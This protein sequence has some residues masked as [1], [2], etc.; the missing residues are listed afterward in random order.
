[1]GVVYGSSCCYGGYPGRTRVVRL[2]ARVI[3]KDKKYSLI[4]PFCVEIMIEVFIWDKARNFGRTFSSQ[5]RS[6]SSEAVF[7][8]ADKFVCGIRRWITVG[9]YPREFENLNWLEAGLKVR[10]WVRRLSS[11]ASARPVRVTAMAVSLR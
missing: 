2:R 1:M 5:V 9:K 4:W 10:L 11:R 6:N 7:W 8:L 3:R